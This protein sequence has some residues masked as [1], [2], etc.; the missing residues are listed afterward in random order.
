MNRLNAMA[1]F[2]R[3]NLG[4]ISRLAVVQRTGCCDFFKLASQIR[5]TG[6]TCEHFKTAKARFFL[7]HFG[8]KLA[9][10]VRCSLTVLGGNFLP[11][12]PRTRKAAG[13]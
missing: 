5:L 6:K 4:R 11:Q 7:K 3:L 8:A 2:R 9:R 12:N 10:Q 13:A 1:A